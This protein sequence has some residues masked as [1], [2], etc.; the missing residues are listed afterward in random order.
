M[1]MINDTLEA[2]SGNVLANAINLVISGHIHFF[3]LLN[4]VENR[5]PQ[6]IVGMSGTEVD[7][8]VTTPFPRA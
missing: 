4:F 8:L 1:F 6:L 2:A 5:Q 7:S 3:E